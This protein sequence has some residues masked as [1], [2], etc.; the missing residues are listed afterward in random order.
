M[1]DYPSVSDGDK[2]ESELSPVGAV[3]KRSV[4]INK[5]LC[6]LSNKFYNHPI[7]VINKAIMDFCRE[8]ELFAA[9]QMLIQSISCSQTHTSRRDVT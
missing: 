5:L 6:F 8:D 7:T 3:G 1:R 9:K 2:H 4:L